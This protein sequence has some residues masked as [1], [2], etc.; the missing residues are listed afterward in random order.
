MRDRDAQDVESISYLMFQF[1]LISQA[2]QVHCHTFL[3][4]GFGGPARAWIGRVRGER[5]HR[6]PLALKTQT[7]RRGRRLETG[8]GFHTVELHQHMSGSWARAASSSQSGDLGN[9]AS[10]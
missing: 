3:E 1:P 5:N 10:S 9:P 6:R 8:N 2:Y 7:V 4:K